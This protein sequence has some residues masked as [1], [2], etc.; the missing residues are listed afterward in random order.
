L[1]SLT[2]EIIEKF[3]ELEIGLEKKDKLKKGKGYVRYMRCKKIL[4]RK[5]AS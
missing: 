3:Y 4:W 1:P 2:S 5:N